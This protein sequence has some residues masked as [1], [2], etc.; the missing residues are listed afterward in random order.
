MSDD[1]TPVSRIPKNCRKFIVWALRITVAT[2]ASAGTGCT[3]GVVS[4]LQG[5]WLGQGVEQMPE[6]QTASAT[7]W[8]RGMSFELAGDNLTVAIPSEAPRT[9]PFKVES[10]NDRE[11]RL[12]VQRD[13]GKTDYVEL[14]VEDAHTM[15]WHIG[16]GMS[17]VLRKEG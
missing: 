10:V 7:G 15:R 16:S 4:D 2:A 8:V 9:A 12:A 11:V 5:R 3:P 14:T 1:S 6:E 17:L 13:D